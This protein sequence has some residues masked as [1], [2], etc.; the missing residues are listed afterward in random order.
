ML[1][2]ASCL[3]AGGHLWQ[4]LMW[5]VCIAMSPSILMIVICLAWSG[6][7]IIL[8]IWLFPSDYTP[9]RSSSLL[10]RTCWV[11]SRA[12][13]RCGN[14]TSHKL[15]DFPTLGPPQLAC[16]PEQY[17][18]VYSAFGDWGIPLHLDRLGRG[19][20]LLNGARCWAGFACPS[21]SF[22]AGQV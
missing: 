8:W 15:D 7:A 16:L 4:G 6:E 2:S 12:W 22:S 1:S 14:F 19:R 20:P 13:L 17:G 3:V 11:V 10:L 21:G 9:P 18:Y 5:K